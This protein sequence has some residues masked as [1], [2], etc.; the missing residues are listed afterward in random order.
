MQPAEIIHVD[1]STVACDGGGG[2]LG[3]PLVYLPLGPSGRVDCPYC[4]RR[5]IQDAP[6]K[7]DHHG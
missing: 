6:V 7:A 3:H 1:K 4:G 5:F 2:A